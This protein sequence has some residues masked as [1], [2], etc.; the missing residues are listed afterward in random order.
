M[1]D[2]TSQKDSHQHDNNTSHASF[3]GHGKNKE[4]VAFG[5]DSFDAEAQSLFGNNV[6][7][8][9]SFMDGSAIAS[10]SD[11]PE[12]AMPN[13]VSAIALR[14]KQ[15]GQDIAS[16]TADQ[17][18]LLVRFDELEGWKSSGARNC[19]SWMNLEMGISSQLGWEYLRVGRKM[20]ILPITR[21][22]FRA[23]NLTWSIVRLLLRVAGKDNE[24][25][26]CHTALDASV[27]E[28]ER[29]CH[30]YRWQQDADEKGTDGAENARSLQQINARAFSWKT[31][32]NGNTLVNLSLPPEVAQGFL[33]SVEQSLAQLEVTDASMRQRRADAAVFISVASWIP[34]RSGRGG[35]EARAV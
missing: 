6:R 26:L 19:V 23:G 16:N 17:L 29:L 33:N 11:H 20:R 3:N 2:S 10:K 21:A 14:L 27:S 12:K 15:F 34:R 18:E 25:R 8:S 24:A 13:E 22:L 32:S 30:E 31:V 35:N 4:R 9:M 1:E 28:V 7:L 5:L